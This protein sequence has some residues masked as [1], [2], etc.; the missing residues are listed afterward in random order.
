M[1]VGVA[2]W[3]PYNQ[4]YPFR[5]MK[6]GDSFPVPDQSKKGVQKADVASQV[7]STRNKEYGFWLG[8]QNGE[9]RI[10]RVPS[11]KGGVDPKGV[12][13]PLSET[14]IAIQRRRLGIAI[15]WYLWNKKNKNGI[16]CAVDILQNAASEAQATVAEYVDFEVAAWTWNKWHVKL[17]GEDGVNF[18]AANTTW[19]PIPAAQVSPNS[20]GKM[21]VLA[22]DM[23]E[24]SDGPK[25]SKQAIK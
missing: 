10:W 9:W 16:E 5:S 8:Q 6:I 14:A 20:D 25:E 23:V 17:D 13:K 7:F 21:A 18:K 12:E 11:N 22:M 1:P 3:A 24:T 2:N 4:K 19:T 15:N